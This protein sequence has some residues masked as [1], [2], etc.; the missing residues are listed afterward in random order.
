MND[1]LCILQQCI[2][3]Q[4]LE[5]VLNMFLV[6]VIR[7]KTCCMSLKQSLTGRQ[8]AF[9]VT[10]EHSN[11]TLCSVIRRGAKAGHH[12]TSLCFTVMHTGIGRKRLAC[13]LSWGIQACSIHK[14][15]QS[16]AVCCTL[17]TRCIVVN[18]ICTVRTIRTAATHSRTVY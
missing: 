13:R 3:E 15:W 5:H 1:V 18:R 17:R 4:I 16:L 9:L 6:P 10:V 14:M 2:S 8:A 11:Y 12:N 7:F